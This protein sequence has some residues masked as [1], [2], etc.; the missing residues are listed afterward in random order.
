M[1][2]SIDEGCRRVIEKLTTSGARKEGGVACVPL[3][4]P[5]S[6]RACH[7]PPSSTPYPTYHLAGVCVCVSECLV[8]FCAGGP[9]RF[10]GP[11][12]CRQLPVAR[13]QSQVAFV[14]CRVVLSCCVVPCPRVASSCRVE[15]SSRSC[16]CLI[17]LKQHSQTAASLAFSPLSKSKLFKSRVQFVSDNNNNKI[18]NRK[19]I[20][21][22]AKKRSSNRSK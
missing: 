16:A 4:S 20:K 12:A 15:E 2:E 21:R 17:P 14:S 11:V 10:C 13:C 6:V 18:H 5:C 9:A 1:R 3:A 7:L 22:K 19:E 8:K